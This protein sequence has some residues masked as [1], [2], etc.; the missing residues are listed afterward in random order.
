MTS[1]VQDRATI[2]GP[3]FQRGGLWLQVR[4][5]IPPKLRRDASEAIEAELLLLAIPSIACQGVACPSLR[6]ARMLAT[7]ESEKPFDRRRMI[8]RG[9]SIRPKAR[10]PVGS[11]LGSVVASFILLCVIPLSA[12]EPPGKRVSLPLLTT[13]K[14]VRQLA[15]EQARLGYPVR[16]RG[17]VTYFHYEQED[18]F[19]QDAKAGIYVNPA[20][21]KLPLRSGQLV[22]VEGISGPGDFASE[23][24]NARVRILGVAPMPSPLKVSAEELASGREDSQ[25]VEVEGMVRSADEHQGRLMLNISSGAIQFK[26]FVLNFRPMP[27]SLVDSRVRIRGVSG[28]L[29]NPKNQ[30]LGATVFIP[31]LAH[32]RVEKPAPRDLFSLPVRPIHILL[33][34]SPKGAFGQRVRVQGVVTVQRLGRSLYIRDEHEGLLVETNQGTPVEVGDRVDVVGFPSVGGYTPVLEDGIFRKIGHGLPLEPT[35]VSADQAL[36]GAYDAELVRIQARLLDRAMRPGL[37]TLVLQSGKSTFEAEI[38]AATSVE[39]LASLSSGSLLQLTGICSVQVDENREPRSFR[40]LLR[41][42]KDVLVLKRPSWWSFKHLLWAVAMMGILMLVGLAWVSV[43]RSQVRKRT[44]GLREALQREAA[45]QLRYRELFENAKD[46]VYTTDLAG[47]LTSLNKAGEQVTG[48]RREEALRMNIAEMVPPECSPLA[49]RMTEQTA[50]GEGPSTYELE[51]LANDG[52]RVPLEVIT[53]LINEQGKPVGVQA[54][55]RDIT[56]RQQAETELRLSEERF[57]KAFGTSPAAITIST[58]AEGLYI[59]VNESYLRITGRRRE[60]VIGRTAIEL[61]FWLDPADRARMLEMLDKQGAIRDMEIN[62]GTKS[63]QIRSG[64]LSAEVI[65]DAGQQ[66]LLAVTEDITDRKRAEETLRQLPGR[67][68]KFQDEERRRI[69]RELHDVTGQS[70]AALVMS[71]GALVKLADKLSPRARQAFS[72]SLALAKQVSREV[73]TLSYL[74]HPPML[75]EFGLTAALRGYVEGFRKRSGIHV[76]LDVAPALERLSPD[77]ELTVFRIVQESLTNIHHHAGSKRTSIRILRNTHEL[78]V[79]VV[80]DGRGMSPGT[81][82]AIEKSGGVALGVGI[83]GLRERVKQLEGQLTIQSSRKGTSVT[84]ILPLRRIES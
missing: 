59:D 71:L 31:S 30:F 79:K 78:T 23:V 26:A 4:I 48:Y 21:V 75:E 60:E 45:L 70:L 11:F 63:G 17:V 44:A 10:Q 19:I 14:Q 42:P 39:K 18:M 37:E 64:L 9:L 32:V 40:L 54:I 50:A 33:R 84:A 7:P 29:Y 69:A 5:F 6:R 77:L 8:P 36:Q 15:P 46:I 35:E 1:W 22:E 52:R 55:G 67:L 81:L 16:L 72:E 51:I 62:F 58:L 80:D 25:W 3:I 61:K 65:E 83:A 73:R 82:K 38:E 47:N 2:D 28:G 68:L 74:L 27:S 66:C 76:D 41:S 43:L 49:R 56:E 57:R 12:Q 20:Q 53:R 13:A 24:I 34:L